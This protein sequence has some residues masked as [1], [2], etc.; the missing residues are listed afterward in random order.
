MASQETIIPSAEFRKELEKRGG[1]TVARCYQCATCSSVCQL[2]P[3][4]APFP[5]RQMLWAQ[6]G[7]ADRLA[8]DPA[9]WL[10]HQCNDCTVHCPR[11]A[12][13]G[14]VMQTVRS[15]AVEKLSTPGFMGTLV[16]KAGITWPILLGVPIAFWVVVLYAIHGLT[17]PA[18]PLVYDQF[19]P[20][21][22]IYVVFFSVTGGVGLVTLVSAM[23]FWKLMGRSGKRTG[24]FV[25]SAVAVIIEILTHKRFGKCDAA[26]SRRW[27]H[28]ALFWGFV[29][30]ALASGLIIV[31]MYIMHE[32]LPLPLEHPFK[33]IGNLGAVFLVVGGILLLG[34]RLNE[35]SNAG[36]STAYDNFFLAVVLLVISTG[37]LIEIGRFVFDPQLACWLYIL[38]LGSVLCLFSTFPYSKF[39]HILYRTLAMI[40]ER[41]T[42]SK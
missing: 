32:P 20:H 10:C 35:N 15:M 36:A 5:R 19:V 3:A 42:V 41:M 28:F 11:D 34:N 13:P 27:G 29:W 1:G 21:W 16:A 6:W 8:A 23:K 9:V 33:M 30:A 24:S 7:L 12:R 4:D 26:G 25:G 18:S 38:H 14:D 2:A 40:H 37:V 31:A 17:I 22:L 39:A